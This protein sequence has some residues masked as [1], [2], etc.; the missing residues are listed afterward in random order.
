MTNAKKLIRCPV[1]AALRIR[2]T[3]IRLGVPPHLSIA[4]YRNPAGAS[5]YIDD[6]HVTQMLQSLATQVYNI[7]NRNDL[8]RFT[9]HSLRVGACVLLH[10]T[11]QTPDFIKARLRW[12]SDAYLMYLRN[13]PKLANMYNA[14]IS[15]SAENTSEV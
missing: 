14:E 13:T 10:E 7:K 11:S 15:N 12:R 3:A 6:F 2:A 5:Q 1:R 4:I 9:T 8:V